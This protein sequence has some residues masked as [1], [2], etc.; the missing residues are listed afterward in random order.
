MELKSTKL[1][2]LL[3][4][5]LL[6]FFLVGCG[7]NNSSE[8]DIESKYLKVVYVPTSDDSLVVPIEKYIVL[9]FTDTLNKETINNSTIYLLDENNHR[10]PV[11]L[12]VSEKTVS[13]I[14]NEYFI[15]DHLYTIVVT[16]DV[17]DIQGRSL[18]EKFTYIFRTIDENDASMPPSILNQS[19]TYDENQVD[20]TIVASVIASDNV[21]V[22]SYTFTETDT[23]IS[24]DEYFTIDNEGN[25][26]ITALGAV[27]EMNDFEEGVNTQDYN[28]TV[29]DGAGNSASATV[30]LNVNNVTD[31]TSID[32]SLIRQ[33]GRN[34]KIEFPQ[35]IDTSRTSVSGDYIVDNV[36]I[37]PSNIQYTGRTVNI[38]LST[39]DPALQVTISGSIMYE[40]GTYH[41]DGTSFT[42]DIPQN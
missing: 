31:S 6:L 27:S 4:F 18:Y 29:Y 12:Y 1:K 35:N 22:T 17:E 38:T 16:T 37:D 23:S 24:I 10:P 15:A 19:Y 39:N 9:N 36:L 26:T 30:T 20:N 7:S 3:S 34:L 11:E 2:V 40:D 33:V 13:I 14:P 21:A 41:N 32:S 25:I 8:K 42:Y 5:I 28:I